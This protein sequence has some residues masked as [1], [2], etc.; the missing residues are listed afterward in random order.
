MV[1]D[2]KS[3]LGE[4]LN[5]TNGPTGEVLTPETYCVADDRGLI[6]A[7]LWGRVLPA[8]KLRITTPRM[9]SVGG[10]APAIARGARPA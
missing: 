8:P 10:P 3:R 5:A 9:V 1:R 4:W 2:M 6:I 7:G